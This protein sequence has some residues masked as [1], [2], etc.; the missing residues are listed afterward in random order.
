MAND[1]EE[2]FVRFIS[3]TASMSVSVPEFS[4][5]IPSLAIRIPPVVFIGLSGLP[6]HNENRRRPSDGER[7][8]ARDY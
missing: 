2:E 4:G 7:L 8:P 1:E 6:H 5:S 3:A